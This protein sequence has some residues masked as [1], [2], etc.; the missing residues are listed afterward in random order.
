ML[1][2][3]M[4][5]KISFVSGVA[6]GL[7]AGSRIGPALYERV[8]SVISSFA[9][10]P[11]VRRGASVAGDRAT[12]AAKTASATAAQQVKHAGTVV[13]HRFGD[14]FGENRSDESA[15]STNGLAN[16]D[17]GLLGDDPAGTGQ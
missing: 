3:T 15:R 4:K 17:P 16:A 13:A 6:L 5:A 2:V 8:R 14:R 9:G 1:G 10:D 12:H 7:L 11:R